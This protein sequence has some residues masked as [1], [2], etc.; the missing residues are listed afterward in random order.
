MDGSGSGNS[1]LAGHE[2][3]QRKFP[4]PDPIVI[5]SEA[6]NLSICHFERSEESFLFFFNRNYKLEK[7]IK[8][9]RNGYKG[10]WKSVRYIKCRT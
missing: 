2:S 6:K 7:S 5:L 1:L 8:N 3:P 10:F 9:I 4:E